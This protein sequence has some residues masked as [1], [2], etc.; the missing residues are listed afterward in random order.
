MSGSAYG[1][2]AYTPLIEQ[3]AAQYGVPA[4]VLY[5]QLNQESG[6]NP[7]AA[8]SSTGAVGIAQI[9]PSTA[10]D[11]GYGV[12]P[13]SDPSDPNQ[14]IPFAAAYDAALYQ[15]TGSWTGAL[16][17]YGTL[18]SVPQSVTDAWNSLLG[19]G[20]ASEQYPSLYPGGNY[21]GS[22]PGA[23]PGAAATPYYSAPGGIAAPDFSP[24]GGIAEPD[25][26][27]DGSSG[28]WLSLVEELAVRIMLGLVGMV[29]LLAGFYV[30]GQ[31]TGRGPLIS[32]LAR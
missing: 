19:S 18:A 4:A 30:A 13:I 6:L 9:L 25:D 24:P 20:A 16:T 5:W 10:A 12:T 27:P 31:R 15:Q 1:T 2:S 17:R 29:L 7:D 28:G 22:N 21:G 26:G 23:D 8:P 3:S 14:A 11:P 32:A